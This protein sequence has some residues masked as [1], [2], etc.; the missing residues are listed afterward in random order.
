MFMSKFVT[1]KLDVCL[2]LQ[3]VYMIFKQGIVSS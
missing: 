2:A 1:L 3:L